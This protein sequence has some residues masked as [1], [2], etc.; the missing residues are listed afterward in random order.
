MISDSTKNDDDGDNS[1]N[2]WTSDFDD[3]IGDD[4]FLDS[5][6]GGGSGSGSSSSGA[7][8][9][10]QPRQLPTDDKPSDDDVVVDDEGTK[11]L[12]RLLQE[13]IVAGSAGGTTTSSSSPPTTSE[14]P[15]S[16]PPPPSAADFPQ[17]R[18]QPQQRQD[19]TGI[20]ARR[21]RLGEDLM[22]TRYVGDV[23]FDEVTDWEYYY[24]A[25]DDDDDGSNDRNS[26][27][28]T[29]QQQQQQR[30][31][32][33]VQP[34]PFDESTPRRTRTKSGSVIRIFLAEY[35]GTLGGLI[36]AQG[37]DNRVL[38]KEYSGKLA[39]Q[40]ASREL[41]TIGQLQSNL[42]LSDEATPSKYDK[43]EIESGEWVMTA[44]A[45]ATPNA[46]RRDNGN[47]I[48]LL[49]TLVSQ[50]RRRSASTT[51]SAA[52]P[53]F[54]GIVGEVDIDEL[55]PGGDDDENQNLQN[56]FYR[57]LGVVGPA[58]DAIW[59]VFE[60]AS[61]SSIQS[62]SQ[63]AEKRKASIPPQRGFFGNVVP[64]PPLPPW[65]ERAEYVVK[66][67]MGR[68]ID[69]VA[70]LHEQGIVHRSLG[71]SSILVTSTN[72]DKRDV[73][74]PY[75]TFGACQ[76]QLLVKLTDFGFSGLVRES[77]QSEEFCTRARTFGLSF[78]ANEA[79]VTSCNFAIAEDMH[80]L[81][82]V[83]LSLLLSSLAETPTSTNNFPA[84]PSAGAVPVATD[85]DALQRLYVDI[86]DKDL[87]GQ[88]RDYILQED[89]WIQ[90]VELLDKDDNAGW[91]ALE[92]LLM[93]RENVAAQIQQQQQ[94]A[95]AS[96]ILTIRGLLS[97]SFF[98]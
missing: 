58:A 10:D 97:S 18:P 25:D 60:Y 98:Q 56:E 74:S 30:R 43:Q 64:P 42:L 28:K 69:A 94:P 17:S 59:I 3:Y 27:I 40:L 66:G 63:P 50:K 6:P 11:E 82:F 96:K 75:A 61:L 41:D 67:I 19:L 54:L 38:I 22:V 91:K 65:R 1:N 51:S 86:F 31:R 90:L 45:R 47:L 84:D 5:L 68:A 36:R 81:G 72:L 85:E 83:F 9:Q 35:G 89:C 23:G 33:V 79:T 80:A 49:Q 88:F 32:E 52:S 53:S 4:G 14:P 55:L 73:V 71:K 44:T 70:H 95:D 77:T 48:R 26:N 39:L 57:S 34:N 87:T 8:G 2:E 29:R 13:R 16:S 76:S 20:K 21:L 62:I 24:P 78:R 15:E 92:T 93:A 12:S 37:G 46:G 7:S